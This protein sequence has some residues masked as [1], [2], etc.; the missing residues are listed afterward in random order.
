MSNQAK[1]SMLLNQRLEPAEQEKVERLESLISEKFTRAGLVVRLCRGSGAS[2]QRLLTFFGDITSTVN[3]G[4]VRA[5][6]FLTASDEEAVAMID[7]P[8][9]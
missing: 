9:S 5:I 2:Q 1:V 4:S 6:D 7:L 8:K 3:V